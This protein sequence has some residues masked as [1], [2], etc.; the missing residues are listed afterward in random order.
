MPVEL[1]DAFPGLVKWLTLQVEGMVFPAR[2]CRC[3]ESTKASKAFKGNAKSSVTGVLG[4]LGGVERSL[5]VTIPLCG[6]CQNTQRRRKIASMVAGAVLVSAL[7]VAGAATFPFTTTDAMAS[8]GYRVAIVIVCA[9]VGMGL[10][11]ARTV[12]RE[13]VRLRSYSERDGTVQVW[14]ENP[15]FRAS[16]VELNLPSSDG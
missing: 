12:R 11:L 14:F 1:S 2:C 4:Q 13:P 9:I 16:V 3:G 15:D 10:G 5:T 7:G 8:I 6:S